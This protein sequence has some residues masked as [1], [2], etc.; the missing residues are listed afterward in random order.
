MHELRPLLPQL[1]AAANA[2]LR[3]QAADCADLVWALPRSGAASACT[4]GSSGGE[5]G[6]AG[7]AAP[8]AQL[9]RLFQRLPARRR[10]PPRLDAAISL[11]G[12]R[13]RWLAAARQGCV[14][15]LL[16]PRPTAALEA[17]YRPLCTI[18]LLV[19]TSS[20][21]SLPT[22]PPRPRAPPRLARAPTPAPTQEG[23]SGREGAG[24]KEGG[25][26][27]QRVSVGDTRRG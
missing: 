20:A 16:R 25:R 27:R 24:G 5:R 26:K 8:A 17:N 11:P 4:S 9:C 14:P 2:V 13:A 1:W 10:R 19:R 3:R 12:A 18:D 15:A 6:Q 21:P 23:P 7:A 22:R